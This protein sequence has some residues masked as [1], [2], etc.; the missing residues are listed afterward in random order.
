LQLFV[1]VA[2]IQHCVRSL[3]NQQRLGVC[4]GT[5]P[6]FWTVCDL[7]PYIAGC[8]SCYT[9]LLISLRVTVMWPVWCLV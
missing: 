3:R 6:Q 1:L 7:G 8:L 5:D 4:N 9:L 2:V